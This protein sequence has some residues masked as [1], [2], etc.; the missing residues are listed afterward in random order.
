MLQFVIYNCKLLRTLAISECGIF[1]DSDLIRHLKLQTVSEE[2]GVHLF[3][4]SKSLNNTHF[5]PIV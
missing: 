2:D 1:E 3:I 5:H 4:S